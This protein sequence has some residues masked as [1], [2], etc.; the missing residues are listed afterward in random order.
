MVEMATEV[1]VPVTVTTPAL[2]VGLTEA[3]A[4]QRHQ[5]HRQGQSGTRLLMFPPDR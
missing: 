2:L 1:G 5:F 4:D 3:R